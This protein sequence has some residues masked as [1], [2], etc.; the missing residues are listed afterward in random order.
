MPFPARK[1]CARLRIRD[2]PRRPRMI[3]RVLTLSKSSDL[4]CR[5]RSSC[6][7]LWLNYGMRAFFCSPEVTDSALTR[8]STSLRVDWQGLH[9]VQ[10][11]SGELSRA[12]VCQERSSLIEHLEPCLQLGISEW[13][14]A[15]MTVSGMQT[16]QARVC[17]RTSSIYGVPMY[18]VLKNGDL[19]GEKI[20]SQC[21]HAWWPHGLRASG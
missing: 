12:G 8:F 10:T 11:R 21:H 18:S 7:V 15:G 3:S 19:H 16:M 13:G 1:R 6:V 5:Q 2:C 14:G 4:S 17:L 9:R 20:S